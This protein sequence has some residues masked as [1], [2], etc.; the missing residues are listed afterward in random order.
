MELRQ[1][2]NMGEMDHSIVLDHRVELKLPD[3]VPATPEDPLNPLLGLNGEDMVR[4][5]VDEISRDWLQRSEGDAAWL[6]LIL[7][8][9]LNGED[10]VIHL[11]DDIS[12]DSDHLGA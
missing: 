8:L 6:T 5:L 7:R 9:R 4:P 2:K 11:V 3:T 12:R 1:T 10:M